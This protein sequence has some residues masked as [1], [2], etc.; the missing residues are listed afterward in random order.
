[1]NLGDIWTSMMIWF[2]SFMDGIPNYLR[3]FSMAFSTFSSIISQI[4]YFFSWLF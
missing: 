3:I 4:A 2:S 1:M